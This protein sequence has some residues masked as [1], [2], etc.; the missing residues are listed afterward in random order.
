MNKRNER[1]AVVPTSVIEST[2]NWTVCLSDAVF[3][4][5][6]NITGGF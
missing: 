4:T 5:H 1:Y 2:L 3:C 6:G